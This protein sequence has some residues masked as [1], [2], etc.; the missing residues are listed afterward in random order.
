ME[1]WINRVWRS[2]NIVMSSSESWSAVAGKTGLLGGNAVLP[3]SEATERTA[4]QSTLSMMFR[5]NSGLNSMLSSCTSWHLDPSY[6]N[7]KLSLLVSHALTEHF[8]KLVVRNFIAE[9]GESVC[10]NGPDYGM[11]GYLI[12]SHLSIHCLIYTIDNFLFTI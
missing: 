6:C 3:K 10:V 12:S 4:F 8:R 5:R 7:G 2:L 9:M 11:T 1:V